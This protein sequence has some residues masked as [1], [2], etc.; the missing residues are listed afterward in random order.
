MELATRQSVLQYPFHFVQISMIKADTIGSAKEPV[1]KLRDN[2]PNK[3]LKF[4]A[5]E[6]SKEEVPAKTNN[7]M[8]GGV[9]RHLVVQAEEEVG[10][11]P[12]GLAEE[13]EDKEYKGLTGEMGG[14]QPTG[15]TGEVGKQPEGLA[16]EEED[17][18][19]EAVAED[20]LDEG[21]EALTDELKVK[22]PKLPAKEE[23]DKQVKGL[24]EEEVDNHTEGL[25]Q[26]GD[27]PPADK[28]VF[29]HSD[30]TVL[31][32]MA[33]ETF[34]IAEETSGTTTCTVAAK[35]RELLFGSSKL[36]VLAKN[37]GWVGNFVGIAYNE[38]ADYT[39][40]ETMIQEIAH[41]VTNLC[42]R[43]AVAILKF[44]QASS[45]L[46]E[47]QTTY[48]YLLDGKEDTCTEDT[49][50]NLASLSEV[51]K[52]MVSA[53]EELHRGFDKVSCKVEEALKYTMMEEGKKKERREEIEE[54][55]RNYEVEM[56]RA[57]E[58]SRVS[59]PE[60][61]RSEQRYMELED[62]E[63][64]RKVIQDIAELAKQI[65]DCSDDSMLTMAATEA[66][67]KA[68]GS[69]QKLSVVMLHVATF[70]EQLQV[71]CETLAKENLRKIV[72]TAMTWPEKERLR[73]WTHTA[74]K[75]H[76]T[77]FHKQWLTLDDVCAVCMAK[78]VE[79]QKALCGYL[80]ENPAI[81]EAREN[82]KN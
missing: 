29:K 50:K 10:K 79:T 3:L 77:A 49:L 39:E 58:Y 62:E 56:I 59:V 40:L 9:Y 73:L 71:H 54:R 21:P 45:I 63:L 80:T 68:I 30:V 41:E 34:L 67:H 4:G 26:V 12:T 24:A 47:L 42:E 44:K 81:E 74:F 55:R 31:T 37:L 69:L 7:V 53:G 32:E 16:E 72:E 48:Q 78:I 28:G 33:V 61:A 65:E 52:S 64:Q 70:W 75:T 25:A 23:V 46:D 38:A 8:T 15:P 60:H 19:L 35:Q 18:Q 1:E 22:Q 5:E 36:K 17:K 51:A 27:K 14:K 11:Q 76:A 82:I 57:Q 66:L 20:K 43:S 13:G 6:L 2:H